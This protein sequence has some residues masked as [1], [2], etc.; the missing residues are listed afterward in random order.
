MSLEER[1]ES[2]ATKDVRVIDPESPVI[3]AAGMMV[4]E[5]IGCLIVTS[6]NGATGI[7][8]ERDILRKVTAL[9][10]D[11]REVLVKEVMSSPLVSVSIHTTVGETAK[12]MSD[13]GVR[14]LAI[15]GDG[16][17]LVGLVTMTD[18]VR[19]MASQE[20]LSDSLMNY[21]RQEVV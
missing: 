1:V 16:G 7:V 9:G 3:D 12:L 8:T 17:E 21:L 5:G 6:V 20:K 10:R 2:I 18:L 14:R 15:T 19:W 13:Q 4:K 11:P